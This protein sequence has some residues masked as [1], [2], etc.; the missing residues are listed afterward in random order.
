MTLRPFFSYYGGKWRS[1][2]KH[3]PAPEFDQIVE[4]FAGFQAAFTTDR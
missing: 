1:A 3:Y 4:P 2:V